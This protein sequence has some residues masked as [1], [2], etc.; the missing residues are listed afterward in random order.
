MRNG[1]GDQ[2]LREVG[3]Y[4]AE[5]AART[6]TLWE[7]MTPTASCNHGFASHILYWMDQLGMIR[8]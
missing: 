1:R 8:K 2:L 3:G 4:F 6:G 5:M 7:N